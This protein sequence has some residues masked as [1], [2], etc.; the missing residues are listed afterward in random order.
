METNPAFQEVCEMGMI[1]DSQDEEIL[2]WR[3]FAKDLMGTLGDSDFKA[4]LFGS[5]LRHRN[6]VDYYNLDEPIL[7]FLDIRHWE[8]DEYRDR[9]PAC[10]QAGME[11]AGR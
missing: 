4:V 2:F 10:L 7:S 11:E 5:L 8:L 3:H 9:L 1:I 6:H